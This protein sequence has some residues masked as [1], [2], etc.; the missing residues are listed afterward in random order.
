MQERVLD[1]NLNIEYYVLKIFIFLHNPHLVSGCT[2]DQFSPEE[3][4]LFKLLHISHTREDLTYDIQ[5]SLLNIDYDSYDLLCLG[6]D[7]D[8]NTSSADSTMQLWNSIFNFSNPNTLWTLGNHD[9]YDRAL[10]SQYTERPSYY[11]WSNNF[12]TVV[13]LDLSLIHI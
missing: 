3:S 10:I 13:V 1:K 9:T 12:L 8:K 5:P 4:P 6:G 2:K 7:I 11:S